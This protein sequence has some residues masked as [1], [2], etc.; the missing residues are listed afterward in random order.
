MKIKI[1]ILFLSSLFILSACATPY[2]KTGLGGGFSETQLSEN[3]F[4]VNFKGN[5]YTSTQRAADFALLRSAELTLKNGY[6]Y[7]VLSD[8]NNSIEH[9]SY[10]T[11]LRAHTRGHANTYGTLN[12]YGN[13]GTYSGS[14]DITTTTY[15]RGGKTYNIKK[16]TSAK[17]IVCFKEKPKNGFS[18]DA[19][20]LKKSLQTK[21]NLTEEIPEEEIEKEQNSLLK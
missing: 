2:Q 12:T 18:F 14:T 11:P 6:K 9:S 1:K 21:Y 19:E 5:S 16:P 3:I 10:T 13:F 15:F 4:Q 8:S 17:T 7:F 20:F